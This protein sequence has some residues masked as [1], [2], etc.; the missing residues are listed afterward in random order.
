MKRRDFLINSTLTAGGLTLHKSSILYANDLPEAS[1]IADYKPSLENSS[2][3]DLSYKCAS[4][5]EV[6]CQH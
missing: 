2:A 3:D 6:S 4:M 5:P 1:K